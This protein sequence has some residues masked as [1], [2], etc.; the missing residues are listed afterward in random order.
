MSSH[1]GCPHRDECFI[2]ASLAAV[3]IP[4]LRSY[5]E[6]TFANCRYYQRLTEAVRI[7]KLKEVCA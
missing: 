6:S 5:C 4:K 3:P 7:E 1:L 2:I